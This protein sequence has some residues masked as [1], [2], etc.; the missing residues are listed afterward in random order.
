MGYLESCPGGGLLGQIPE[1]IAQRTFFHRDWAV[2]ILLLVI[3]TIMGRIA[4][5]TSGY[6]LF[7][8]TSDREQLPFPTAPMSALSSMALAEESGDE[9][10]VMEMARV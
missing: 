9:K 2:P 4:W 5:F 8:L 10:G 3:G 6:M 7:R 1:A